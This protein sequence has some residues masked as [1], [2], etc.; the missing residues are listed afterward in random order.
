MDRSNGP[1]WTGINADGTMDRVRGYLSTEQSDCVRGHRQ[2]LR[3]SGGPAD[4][5]SKTRSLEKF[6]RAMALDGQVR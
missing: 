6:E 5:G 2:Y 4:R 3:F 1:I